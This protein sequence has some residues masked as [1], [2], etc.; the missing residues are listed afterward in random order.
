MT[1]N[2]EILLALDV[3]ASR[4]GVAKAD[5]V[6]RI[7]FPIGTLL[8]DGLEF[9]HFTEM[10]A[11]HQPVAL[12]VGYPRNQAG[13]TTEQTTYVEQ[14]AKQLERYQLPVIFQDESLTSVI[15]EKRLQERGKSY[16]K[17]DIDAE[18][19]TIILNDY[20]EKKYGY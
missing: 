5:S 18:A 1:N 15:A 2:P 17:A 9:D 16:V 20:L 14:F 6:T 13:G 3:G 12:V 7:P 8:V 19:A 11:E 4:I 10:I